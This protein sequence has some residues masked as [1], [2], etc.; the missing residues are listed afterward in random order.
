MNQED[1]FTRERGERDGQARPAWWAVSPSVMGAVCVILGAAVICAAVWMFTGHL[2]QGVEIYGIVFPQWGIQQVESRREG[3]V[4]YCQVKVGESVEAGDLIAI[5]PHTGLLEE[6]EAA[7]A[8]GAPQEE[9]DMLY[10]RYQTQSMVYSPVSGRVVELAGQGTHIEVGD[11]LAGITNSGRYTNEAEIRAYVPVDTAQAI[12]KGMEVRIYPQYDSREIRGYLPGIVSEISSYPITQA[13]ISRDL[14]RFYS[15]ES[16][17]QS[18]SVVEVRVTIL[19]GSGTGQEESLDLNTLCSM[20][21]VVEE[22]TPWEWLRGR[23][24]QQF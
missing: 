18:G 1:I 19:S 3:T 4:S 8:A 12:S 9:L 7:Q 11:T 13:D 2:V 10:E 24:Y 21:V 20:V 16:V 5:I 6:L 22:M 14:G 17:P 15:S 23:W